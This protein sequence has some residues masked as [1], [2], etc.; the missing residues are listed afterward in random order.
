MTKTVDFHVHIF[1]DPL[2]K[3]AQQG[4]FRS[5][6]TWLS[7]EKVQNVRRQA[8]SWAKPVTGSLHGV[9]TILRHFPNVTRKSMDELC[10]LIPLP[11][12]LVESTPADLI[13]AMDEAQIDFALAIAH[14]PYVSNEF[15]LEA[16]AKNP[17]LI[18]AVNI[19]AGTTRP[20]IV[21]KEYVKKGAKV[22]KIHAA[23]DG[24]GPN[25]PRYRKLIK[26]ASE[27]GIPVVIHTGCIHSRLFY[28]DPA[29]G[30]AEQ[31]VSWFKEYPETR[32]ILA[33]MNFHEPGIALDICEEY[34]NVYVD[35]SWQPAEM[36]G[37]AARRIGAERVLFGT[38]WPLVGNN[39]AVGRK[40]IDESIRIGLLN[41]EQA[42]LI[43]GENAMKLLGLSVN[44]D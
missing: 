39:M 13:E 10:G 16:C 7:P 6:A 35:T 43:L 32:F 31:F 33:H 2:E 28:K 30:K 3:I 8:R 23:S 34:P 5:L 11:G 41:T 22:L 20:G 27:E 36:I 40:R 17:R 42:R 21:L 25:S 37:E 19:P 9:Q 29:Y 26:A 1:S 14:P 15:V 12:L 24:E 44:A 18:A 4:A 38:D